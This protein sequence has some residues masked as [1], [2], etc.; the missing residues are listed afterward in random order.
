MCR[1]HTRGSTN[2][3]PTQRV[4]NNSIN[5]W[6]CSLLA[7]ERVSTNNTSH[8]NF[9]LKKTQNLFHF[10]FTRHVVVSRRFKRSPRLAPASRVACDQI[11]RADQWSNFYDGS[12]LS[13][14]K[15]IFFLQV[16]R[17]YR[18]E[19]CLLPACH[20]VYE[21][22]LSFVVSWKCCSRM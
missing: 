19:N 5:H 14:E 12:S 7:S 6:F 3:Q 16:C 9:I 10:T 11:I 13:L 20:N 2:Q 4:S 17:L 1:V 18:A 22:C 21:C 8:T 15:F